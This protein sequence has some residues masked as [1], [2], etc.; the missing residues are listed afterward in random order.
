MTGIGQ[1]QGVDVLGCR[2]F[3]Q[4]CIPGMR[5]RIV[6]PVEP[7]PGHCGQDMGGDACGQNV[8]CILKIQEMFL[9][10]ESRMQTSDAMKDHNVM[11]PVEKGNQMI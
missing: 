8:Q 11:R 3:S 5:P 2:P 1:L 9:E 6:Y 7:L 10:H 4:Q